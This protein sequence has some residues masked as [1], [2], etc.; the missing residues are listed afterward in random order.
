MSKSGVLKSGPGPVL[1]AW[2]NHAIYQASSSESTGSNGLVGHLPVSNPADLPNAWPDDRFDFIWCLH[3]DS[4]SL[5]KKVGE[6]KI[7]HNLP[8]YTFSQRSQLLLANDID[9]VQS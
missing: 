8:S 2:E 9:I 5:N 3:L 1:V 6:G 4:T 7:V